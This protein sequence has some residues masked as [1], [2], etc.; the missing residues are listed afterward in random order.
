[1]PRITPPRQRTIIQSQQTGTLILQE[2]ESKMSPRNANGRGATRLVAQPNKLYRPQHA[3]VCHECP[4]PN[5]N[6]NLPESFDP[7]RFLS[8]SL[9]RRKD[10]A[11]YVIHLLL[12]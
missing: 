11:R 4:Q 5:L 8:H 12:T 2:G 9:R 7:A 1:M 10:D 3:S 6:F